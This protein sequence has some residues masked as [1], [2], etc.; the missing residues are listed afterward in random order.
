MNKQAWMMKSISVLLSL[1]IFTLLYTWL[2]YQETESMYISFLDLFS[3]NLL[4]YFILFLLIGILSSWIDDV[5]SMKK[6]HTLVQWTIKLV[7]YLVIGVICGI[8]L[9]FIQHQVEFITYFIQQ[10]ITAAIILFIVQ[11]LMEW[12]FRLNQGRK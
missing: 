4:H 10:S 11:L 9:S 7:T 1:I 8:V 5:W 12:I 2:F 6:G 3:S